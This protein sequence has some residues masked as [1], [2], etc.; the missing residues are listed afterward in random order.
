LTRDKLKDGEK[1]MTES[2]PPT[3][4]QTADQP[5]RPAPNA[6]RPTV[7]RAL[8]RIYPFAQGAIP[9]LAMGGVAALCA[10]VVALSIPLALG[11][12]V[13]GPLA[14]GDTAQ[15]MP[16]AL[17]ILGLGVAEAFFVFLRR[18]LVLGPGTQVDGKMRNAIYI[19]LQ[20]LPVSFHDKWQS[21]QLLSRAMGDVS[22]V[23][24]WLSFGIV[25]LVVNGV[26]IAIG[27]TMLFV[28]N[29]LL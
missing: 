27:F 10:A 13:D 19:H 7:F 28:F 3:D 25:M 15:I 12:M 17:V 6:E 24:R 11:W 21:G 26:T 20:K 22:T 14:S 2:S 5:T 23:R 9:R 18:A 8:L 29:P 16:T 4:Q 1:S